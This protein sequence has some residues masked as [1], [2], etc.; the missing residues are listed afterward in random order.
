MGAIRKRYGY[1]STYKIEIPR[2]QQT[3]RK[4]YA[5]PDPWNSW[6]ISISAPFSSRAGRICTV[7]RS[8]AIMIHVLCSAKAWPAHM[9]QKAVVRRGYSQMGHK[10]TLPAPETKH[11]SAGVQ[12]VWVFFIA[13]RDEIICRAIYLGI[14]RH[15]PRR[16]ECTRKVKF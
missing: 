5:R 7:E 8:V 16:K 15:R 12:K 4:T 6:L 3:C 10:K 2:K 9:L 11:I 14:S 1:K 13:F